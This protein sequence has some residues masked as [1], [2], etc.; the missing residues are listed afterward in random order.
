MV[1]MAYVTRRCRS[2][3]S[4]PNRAKG[5]SRYRVYL[6]P[7]IREVT[8]CNNEM[9]QWPLALWL[10]WLCVSFFLRTSE[11][12]FLYLKLASGE[13]KLLILTFGNSK[14]SELK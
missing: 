8:T 13:N 6:P 12:I 3:E 10:A 4:D 11:I 5:Q 9:L 2:K 7:M 1:D 14:F